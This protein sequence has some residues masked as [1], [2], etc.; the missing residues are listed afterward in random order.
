MP[1]SYIYTK[2]GGYTPFDPK[3]KALFETLDQINPIKNNKRP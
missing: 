2:G 1:A 3:T